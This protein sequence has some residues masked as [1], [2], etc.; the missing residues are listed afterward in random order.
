[1]RKI[2]PVLLL[3]VGLLAMSGL[4]SAQDKMPV[5][6]G[7]LAQA[8]CSLLE[9]SRDA[10]AALTATDLSFSLVA[11]AENIPDM[12]VAGPLTVS[13]TGKGT[14]T[15]DMSPFY[16][17]PS[18]DVISNPAQYGAYLQKMIGGFN[19]DLQLKLSLP[20]QFLAA[21]STPIP[22]DIP[23]N[24]RLVDGKGYVDFDALTNA[25]GADA[26]LGLPPGWGGMDLVSL[27]NQGMSAMDV[28]SLTGA[29][30]VP[31]DLMN[32]EILQKYVRVERLADDQVSGEAVAV[33]QTTLDLQGLLNDTVV[34]QAIDQAAET[35]DRLTDEQVAAIKQ[36][37][38][39]LTLTATQKI[40][41][42]DHFVRS[43]SVDFTFDM[44]ELMKLAATP[45]AT[46]E[47]SADQPAPVL[48][49]SFEATAGNFNGGQTISA[50]SNAIMLDAGSSEA[51][52]S[53][54]S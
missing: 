2:V 18:K 51:T 40:G 31:S 28:D 42:N 43:T 41:L 9:Q 47:A 45:E 37:F 1:M 6:C 29:G 11:T 4:A 20:Q 13:L 36:A 34:Q 39:G 8:D 7:A 46:V 14:F 16:T 33:F 30:D 44:T 21:T 38:N 48:K 22:A 10:M 23:I 53:P 17:V 26:G 32:P 25:F 52:E 3:L 12:P 15:G 35:Q 50:P 5:A 27:I 24:V 19:G 49:L 54:L